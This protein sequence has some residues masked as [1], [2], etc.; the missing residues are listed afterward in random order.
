MSPTVQF[1]LQNKKLI[2]STIG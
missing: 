2:S 1:I